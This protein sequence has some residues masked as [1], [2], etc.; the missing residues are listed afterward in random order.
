LVGTGKIIL[1]LGK[2]QVAALG[3]VGRG[4]TFQDEPLI[5]HNLTSDVFGNFSGGK[6]HRGKRHFGFS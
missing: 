6:G 2:R 4:K 1:I 3:P 5:T